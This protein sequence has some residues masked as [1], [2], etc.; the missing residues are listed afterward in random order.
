MRAD[1]KENQNRTFVRKKR[2]ATA[3]IDV[4]KQGRFS[5]KKVCIEREAWGNGVFVI[6][7]END[8]QKR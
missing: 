3:A 4:T 6:D 7:D 2:A 5:P 8:T 1:S